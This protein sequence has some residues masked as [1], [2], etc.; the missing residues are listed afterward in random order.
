MT[1]LERLKQLI[2][3]TRLGLE[4]P[5]HLDIELEKLVV[6]AEAA[7]DFINSDGDYFAWTEDERHCMSR[8]RDALA[9]LEEGE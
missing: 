9:A 6:V 7:K 4:S 2:D 1:T 5:E 8:L 3:R